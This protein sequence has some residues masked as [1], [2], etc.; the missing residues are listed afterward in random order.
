MTERE[1]WG[2]K[3]GF[4]LATA[5]SAVG[6]GS[7]WRFPYVI[8]TSGGGAFVLLYLFFTLL[9]GIPLFIAEV[10]VGRSA[11]KSSVE[12]YFTLSRS[13]N[14]R[15]LGWLNLATTFIVL[16]YY[17]VVSGWALNY[18]LMSIN[19]FTKGKSPD[20]I[21]SI[22][23][24]VYS[25][26]ES[27]VFWQAVFLSLTGGV[28]YSGIRKGIE[29]W[30]Q[31]FMPALILALFGLFLFSMPLPGFGQA[32]EFTLAPKFSSIDSSC[33]LNA[34]GMAFWTLSV[35]MGII[36]TYGSY[37]NP[38]DDI[39]KTGMIIALIS[40]IVSVIAALMIFSVVFSFG[41]PASSG[42]GLIF[43]TLPVLFAELPGTLLISTLFFS[44]FIFA[45]LTSSISILE[46]LVANLIEVFDI[47]RH[48]ATCYSCAAAFIFGIPS[49]LSGSGLLFPEWPLLYGKTFF[50]TMDYIASS[51]MMPLGGIFCAIFV[52]WFMDRRKALQEFTQG[53]SWRYLYTP[54]LFCIRWLVPL[55]IIIIILQEAEVVDVT[56][57]F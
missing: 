45:A 5:G 21:R 43:Q 54:W 22:W 33:I 14:W 17:S 11:Q 27:S 36:L 24:A 41:F 30:S 25:A 20:E 12:A 57:L 50:E 3:L 53:S 13:Y 1:H 7:L 55:A 34:L 8:G 49:A 16:S 10:L 42:P 31:I 48:R 52:G 51:W 6:L 35:G 28:V 2:S 19:Q 32:L 37:M 15:I 38:E 18:T 39:P 23:T 56:K 4:I 40:C 9:I 44:L 29:Y 47:S 26:A 46:V